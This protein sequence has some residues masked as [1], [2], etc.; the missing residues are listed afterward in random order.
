[1]GS[2]VFFLYSCV[3]NIPDPASR[4]SEKSKEMTQA[5]SDKA[6]SGKPEAMNPPR[7][8]EIPTEIE[9]RMG[10]SDDSLKVNLEYDRDVAAIA[11]IIV[12]HKIMGTHDLPLCG[13]DKRL[14][15]FDS[16]QF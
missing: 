12:F 2:A 8:S 3:K 1:L 5:S 14:F 13:V 10:N 9:S 7:G 16:S 6:R 15:P 4:K 11:A